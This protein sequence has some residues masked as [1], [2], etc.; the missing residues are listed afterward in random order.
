MNGPQDEEES[1][2][3][4]ASDLQESQTPA[5][6]PK[7]KKTRENKVGDQ[8]HYGNNA[9]SDCDIGEDCWDDDDLIDDEDNQEASFLSQGTAEKAFFNV[10][11]TNDEEEEEE[12]DDC[13]EVVTNFDR[14]PQM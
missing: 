11:K 6:N 5:P 2:C 12:E 8:K 10:C 3:L 9:H 1:L 13:V 4:L 14:V 7:S